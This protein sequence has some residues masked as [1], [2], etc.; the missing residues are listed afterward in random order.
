MGRDRS[1]EPGDPE[2]DA[3]AETYTDMTDGQRAELEAQLRQQDRLETLSRLR[4]C[5]QRAQSETQSDIH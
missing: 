1:M 5:L 4:E 3:L 2:F